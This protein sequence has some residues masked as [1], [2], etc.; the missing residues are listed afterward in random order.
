LTRDQVIEAIRE[1]IARGSC[2]PTL[3]EPRAEYLA[4]ETDRL[5]AA[6]VDACVATVVGE[7]Y[8]YGVYEQLKSEQPLAIAQDGERWLLLRPA[9]GEFALAYGPGAEQL[10]IWGFSS[11]DALAEWLG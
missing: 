1:S 4:R 6:V 11:S 3:A 8:Q 10:T 2:T 5:L 9:K 7:I